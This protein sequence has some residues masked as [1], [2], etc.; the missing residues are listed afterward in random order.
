MKILFVKF[1]LVDRTL[2]R[3]GY[4]HVVHVGERYDEVN[5][6]ARILWQSHHC[7][8]ACEPRGDCSS[9]AAQAA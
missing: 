2:R 9:H 1:A 4:E 6:V 8:A 3:G 7:A 5:N